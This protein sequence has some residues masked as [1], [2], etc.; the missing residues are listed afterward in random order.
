LENTAGKLDERFR[1]SPEAPGMPAPAPFPH[2]PEPAI[3]TGS[4][5]E[6]HEEG[7]TSRQANVFGRLHSSEVGFSIENPVA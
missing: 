4:L 1:G 7:V 6:C 3:A 2:D 5:A